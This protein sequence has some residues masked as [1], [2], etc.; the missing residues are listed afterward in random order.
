MTDKSFPERLYEAGFTDLVSVIPP[1]AQLLPSSA[2]SQASVGKI[3][4]RRHASGLWAG[5]NWRIADATLDD[6]RQWVIEGANVGLRASRFPGVDIDCADERLARLIEDAALA[7]LG[8]AAVRVGRAPKRLLMYSLAPGAEP[9][10]RMRLWITREEDGQPVKH[11]VEIL[12]EGQQYLVHGTH[13]SGRAYE[14]LTDPTMMDEAEITRELATAFLDQLQDIIVKDGIGAVEREGD[15]RRATHVP[16]ADQQALL[17]PS[18][19]VLRD[20]VALI[21]NAD[22]MFPDRTDY[23]R[24]GYAIKAAAGPQDDDGFEIFAEWASRWDGGVNETVR[25]D[26]RRMTGAKAVGWSY[27]AE[28]ARPFGFNDATLEFEVE[29]EVVRQ[30]QDEAAPELSDQWLAEHIVARYRSVLRYVPQKSSWLVWDSTRWEIDAELKAEDLMKRGL[31]DIATRVLRRGAT[32]K[33]KAQNEKLAHAICAAAK[34]TAVASLVRTDR[35]IAVSLQSLDH[36]PW[37]LNTPGGIVDLKTGTVGPPN[38]DA[39]ATRITAVPPDFAGRCPE[40]TRFLGEATGGD[41]ALVA[42]LQR[43]AGYALTG[44][45]REQQL[46]FIFGPGGNGKSIFLNVLHGVLGDYAQ[47]ATMDT[48]TASYG[49]KHSTDIAS[50]VG[51]RLVTASEVEGGKRW[52]TQRVKSLTGGEPVT[53]RFMRQDNFTFSPQFKLVFVGNHQPEL[54]D[55]DAAMKRRVQMVPF[56]VTPAHVD[57]ELGAK[58]RGEWPAILAWMVDGCL[59]WQKEGLAPPRI[60]TVATEAY[61]ENEDAFGRWMAECADRDADASTPS[62]DLFRSWREWANRNNE[63][64]GSLKRFALALTARGFERWQDGTTRRMGFRGIRI[65][66]QGTALGTLL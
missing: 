51:A 35:A 5:Y 15:G 37:I 65:N 14:W 21:P 9:F 52:D 26:W 17:A 24:V 16:A 33:E 64:E 48:F 6:V 18:I 39:L 44:S 4:G 31:R 25:E 60:V 56:V 63:H 22:A 59:T 43:L 57:K 10:G 12:G 49:D 55:V 45:T 32:A 54:K 1:G 2:I 19:E 30:E 41:S 53:A 50:L 3:P 27:L 11:L 38:M 7:H 58:L 13:P 20:A 23:L 42:Y 36:D 34:V 8:P 28:L 47:V 40:W 62:Q 46:S 29:A 66:N 61:F